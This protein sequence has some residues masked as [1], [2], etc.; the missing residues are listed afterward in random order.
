MYDPLFLIPKIYD[1]PRGSPS[2]FGT[3]T[4]HPTPTPSK[5][6]SDPCTIA[7]ETEYIANKKHKKTVLIK[8]ITIYQYFYF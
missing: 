8:Y 6:M 1:P 2:I 7:A 5:K 3:A 4:L